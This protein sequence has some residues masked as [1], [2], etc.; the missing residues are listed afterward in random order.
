MTVIDGSRDDSSSDARRTGFGIGARLYAAFS[1]AT[2]L[3]LIAVATAWFAFENVR[4]TLDSVA[5]RAV[6]V[7]ATRFQLAVASATAAAI[8]P[9]IISAPT[10]EARDAA[11]QEMETTL[12]SIDA[13]T[14]TLAAFEP[15]TEGAIRPLAESLRA[16]LSSL[17]ASVR[18]REIARDELS[19][20]VAEALD[21]HQA[22][23]TDIKP[24]V[25]EATDKLTVAS[26]ETITEVSET[27]DTL[28]RT[29]VAALQATLTLSSEGQRLLGIMAR[30]ARIDSL[31]ILAEEEQTFAR[32]A[33]DMRNI[34]NDLPKSQDATA[35]GEMAGR[36]MS[37]GFGEESVFA[38]RKGELS[39]ADLSPEQFEAVQQ[40]RTVVDQ[41]IVDIARSFDSD[42]RLYP[43]P[44]TRPRAESSSRA[45]CM[46]S[47]PNPFA[48]MPW[49]PS[50]CRSN[51]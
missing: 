45:M 29:E 32:A 35:L 50:T 4:G 8:A 10:E 41:E 23:L 13:A 22:F 27:I 43:F 12:R 33:I 11:R 38:V 7:L 19:A 14:A 46:V 2:A 6:P 31:E 47:P 1:A 17:D 24:L 39:W 37:F 36:L 48:S 20:A 49:F 16:E 5:N 25:D 28:V 51:E 18:R 26:D 21:T 44:L 40:R 3:T 9:N 30:S 34:I 42:S 15:E